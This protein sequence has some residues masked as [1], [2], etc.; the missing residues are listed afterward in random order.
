MHIIPALKDGGFI[1]EEIAAYT[2]IDERLILHLDYHFGGYAKTNTALLQFIIDFYTETGILLDPVYT[3]KLVFG[4][5]NLIRNDKMEPGSKILWIHTGGLMGLLG[6]R[7]KL[8]ALSPGFKQILAQ[9]KE[10]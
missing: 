4:L 9:L 7:Q 8:E 1:R 2:P 6:M 5:E 10:K 3:G